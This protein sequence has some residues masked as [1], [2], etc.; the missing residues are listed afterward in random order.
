MLIRHQRCFGLGRP[1]KD[2]CKI[3]EDSLNKIN[4]YLANYEGKKIS[5]A[6]LVF[7][8]KE[9]K[10]LWDSIALIKADTTKIHRR[11]SLT[12][13]KLYHD[14]LIANR[15]KVTTE[16]QRLMDLN[17]RCAYIKEATRDKWNKYSPNQEGGWETFAGWLITALAISLGAPFWFDLLSKL[18]K[19]RGSGKIKDSESVAVAPAVTP[20][21]QTI[22]VNTNPGEEA[23]G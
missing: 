3:C 20:P 6:D 22:I 10:R 23:V 15:S 19:I 21:V 4:S 7:H 16:L 13:L 12:G 9:S 11:D 2:S 14:T 17:V 18:V 8:E 5:G 1:W